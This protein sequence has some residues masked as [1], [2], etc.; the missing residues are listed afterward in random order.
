MSNLKYIKFSKTVNSIHDKAFNGLANLEVIEFETN[1]EQ[2]AA[3][4][5][6]KYVFDNCDSLVSVDLPVQL[7]KLGERAFGDNE[8]LETV[9]FAP[10]TDFTLYNSDGTIAENNLYAVFMNDPALKSVIFPKGITSTG[11]LA[12]GSCTSL[13][14]VYIP[15]SCKALDGEAFYNCKAL[16][17][18]E[19][20]PNSQLE[21]IDKK[22]ISESSVIESIVFPNTFLSAGGE[23]PLRNLTSLTYINFGAS[24]TGFTGYSGMYST[25]NKNLVIVLPATFDIASKDQLSSNATILYTGT[26]S[27]AD[28][29]GRSK[30]QSYAEWVAD[31]SPTN[32]SR[33]VYGYNICQAFYGGEHDYT[34]EGSFI[35]D[36]V[37]K[38]GVC[39]AT[40]ASKTPNHNTSAIITY[41]NGFLSTGIKVVTCNN[42]ACEHKVE[43]IAAALVEFVGIT[44]DMNVTSICVGYIID[45]NAVEEY[46]NTGKTFEFGVVAYIPAANA[47]NVELVSAQDG[48]IAPIDANGSIFAEL[49]TQTCAFDFVI[50]GFG[51]NHGDVE[52]AMCPYIYNGEAVDYINVAID[53]FGNVAVA[54]SEYAT[55]ITLNQVALAK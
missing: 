37:S 18:I 17:T 24:F 42:A 52:L 51:S 45:V 28:N 4:Y 15:A 54:Q 13:E 20:A 21:T 55:T 8:K 47:E 10:G 5:I 1:N 44:T 46:K 48:V 2:G 33:I 38:C 16:K 53:N 6:G 11:W 40:E 34:A 9:N 7:K 29:F 32:D 31:G 50:K 49:D 3:L 22:S 14:Y 19:F 35:N 25:N 26:K 27:Q 36:C 30:V 39:Q 23:A 43:T 41:E 12:C